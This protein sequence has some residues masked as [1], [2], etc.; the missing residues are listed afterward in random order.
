MPQMEDALLDL[1]L[2]STAV[3]SIGAAKELGQAMLGVRDFNMVASTVTQINEQLLKAQDALF[4]HNADMSELQ[5]KNIE[6]LQ[7]LRA[8]KELIAERGRY[9]LFEPTKG[10]FVYRVKAVESIGHDGNPVAAQ[11][12]HCVCQRCFDSGVKVVLQRTSFYGKVSLSCNACK[13]EFP[14][15]ESEPY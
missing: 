1:S 5:Q 10:Y 12:D 7:E 4:T 11:P 6:M 9:A 2:I 13:A 8:M 3:R 14:T 15:G